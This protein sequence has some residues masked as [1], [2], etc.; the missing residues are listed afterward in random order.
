MEYGIC[1]GRN[2]HSSH[3]S[4]ER[5][6]WTHVG[7][8]DDSPFLWAL[9]VNQTANWHVTAKRRLLNDRDR[10]IWLVQRLDFQQLLQLNMGHTL[11]RRREDSGVVTLRRKKRNAGGSKRGL[12]GSGLGTKAI[13]SRIHV[14]HGVHVRVQNT[15]SLWGLERRRSKTKEVRLV[16]VLLLSVSRRAR[17]ERVERTV[18]STVRVG[19]FESHG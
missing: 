17:S 6:V 13:V 10:R 5:K 12:E 4:R 1:I 16:L 9:E 19:V 2:E 7:N 3:L 18:S 8:L 14:L 15:S 11:S